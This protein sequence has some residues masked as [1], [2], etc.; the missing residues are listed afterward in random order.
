MI[1][2]NNIDGL[3]NYLYSKILGM[4]SAEREVAYAH[5]RRELRDPGVHSMYSLYGTH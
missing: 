5:I 4:S 2:H 1:I 3:L